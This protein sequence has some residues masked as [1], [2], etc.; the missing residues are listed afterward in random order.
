MSAPRHL[1]FD[2]MD[3]AYWRLIET[4]RAY[5]ECVSPRGLKCVEMR[6]FSFE[7]RLPYRSIY[8]GASRK[9]SARFWAI[10]TLSYIAGLGDQP[11]HADLLVRS[12][13]GMASFLNE[14]TGVFDGAYGTRMRQSL[15]SVVDLLLRDRYSRQA[16]CSIWS[17]GIPRGS[18]DVP[19]TVALHFFVSDGRL[20]LA[21][22]MRSNDLNW[23]TPYDVPAFCA[24]QMHVAHRLGLTVGSY[25][26]H[27]GSL[28]YYEEDPEANGRA[29]PPKV[30]EPAL[31]TFDSS[32]EIPVVMSSYWIEPALRQCHESLLQGKDWSGNFP[33]PWRSMVVEREWRT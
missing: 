3:E 32:I 10:E 27:C 26:H 1:S 4:V 11:W 21:V 25:H 12:N 33:E 17:P 23:G 28:H 5:G 19:C 7:I 6:P 14:D 31:E 16:V 2:T 20:S 18:K 22:Y 29:A 30:L 9:L 8:T 13:R 24:I 15:D